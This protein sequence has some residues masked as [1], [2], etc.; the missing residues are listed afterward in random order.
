MTVRQVAFAQGQI[1]SDVGDPLAVPP[2]L[3]PTGPL[4]FHPT[5]CRVSYISGNTLKIWD[6]L[7]GRYLLCSKDIG[8]DGAA[9]AFSPN[10]HLFTCRTIGSDI[11]LWK[12]SSGDYVIHRKFTLSITSP[13]PLFSPDGNSIIAWNRSMLQLFSLVDSA[14]LPFVDASQSSRQGRPW[15]LGFSPGEKYILF[16]R[17]GSNEVTVVDYQSHGWRLDIDAGMEVY[18]LKV[19]GNTITVEGDRRLV[20]WDLPKEGDVSVGGAVT[21]QV[22]AQTTMLK[23]L[24]NQGPKFT[25]ISPDLCM[26]A[27]I[28]PKYVTGIAGSLTIY[29]V[30]TGVMI[31]GTKVDCDTPWFSPDGKQIWCGMDVGEVQGWEVVKRSGSPKIDL[32]P[33]TGSPPKGWPWRSFG[34]Y[35]I[36]DDVLILSP[37]GKQLLLLPPDW[38]S[39]EREMKVWRGQFLALLHGTLSE[40]V[41]LELE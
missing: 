40:P 7:N 22:S 19:N 28:L 21:G 30:E 32:V 18:G 33:L 41:V 27:E 29:D 24:E 34:G 39:N 20:T 38:V 1:H 14:T 36:A 11:H 4:L 10:S 3:N 13:T 31:G 23:G 8:F 2:G 35:T 15:I 25:S 37:E 26:L 9:M 16:A 12:D 5:L 6:S 17:L